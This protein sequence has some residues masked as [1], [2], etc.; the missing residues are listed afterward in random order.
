MEERKYFDYYNAYLGAKTFADRLCEKHGNL[1]QVFEDFKND[2][3]I[4]NEEEVLN[5]LADY[6][7]LSVRDE[8]HN[9]EYYV[10]PNSDGTCAFDG[11]TGIV[12]Y[13][14]SSDSINF[15]AND[16]KNKLLNR[17]SNQ[18][19][20]MIDYGYTYEDCI[21]EAESIILILKE[22]FKDEVE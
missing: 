18:T 21:N 8:E 11:E 9:C 14:T 19:N 17:L 5:N 13:D 6:G 20:N 3:E 22:L 1:K 16:I 12:S 7:W 2:Y 4:N 10:Y 15:F